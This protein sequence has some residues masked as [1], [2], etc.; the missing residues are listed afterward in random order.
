MRMTELDEL[1]NVLDYYITDDRI[2]AVLKEALD[3][4]IN[5]LKEQKPVKPDFNEGHDYVYNAFRCGECGH[6][7]HF[8]ARYCEYCG[9]GVL[10]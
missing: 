7:I 4:A 2:P 10:W 9:R 8:G 3:D 6:N 5:R 1:I